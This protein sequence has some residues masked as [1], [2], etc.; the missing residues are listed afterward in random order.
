MKI[1]MKLQHSP[2]SIATHTAGSRHA[3]AGTPLLQR[4]INKGIVYVHCNA[5]LESSDLLKRKIY[6]YVY[7]LQ[8]TASWANNFLKPS[9]L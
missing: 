8:P 5:L 6:M 7:M 2:R 1:I 9:E 4:C 3:R